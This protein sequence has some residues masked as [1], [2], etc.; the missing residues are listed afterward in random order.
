M[1]VSKVIHYIGHTKEGMLNITTYV[2]TYYNI[3]YILQ[4]EYILDISK[5]ILSS[6]QMLQC[7]YLFCRPCSM[8]WKAFNVEE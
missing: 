4:S 2:C 6:E 1:N 8:S 3:T 5:H 7:V